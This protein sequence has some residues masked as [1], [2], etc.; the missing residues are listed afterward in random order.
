MKISREIGLVNCKKLRVWVSNHP[1]YNFSCF[2]RF[3]FVIRR[4][5]IKKLQLQRY[6]VPPALLGLAS[7]LA[8]VLTVFKT[9][10]VK[11]KHSL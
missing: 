7:T 11:P 1:V 10:N 5:T 2:E 3:Q 6:D 8:L 4:I 9:V